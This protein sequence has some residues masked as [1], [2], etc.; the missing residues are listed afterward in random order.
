MIIAKLQSMHF[1]MNVV[2]E[3][4]QGLDWASGIGKK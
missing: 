4:C 1:W 3:R 2:A